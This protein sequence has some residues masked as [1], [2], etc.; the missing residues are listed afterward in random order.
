LRGGEKER[1]RHRGIHGACGIKKEAKQWGKG[2]REEEEE[3]RR[4]S[5][6]ERESRKKKGLLLLR[7]RPPPT[8]DVGEWR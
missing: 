2:G 3:E 6:R 4:E 1:E 5:E 7:L 8:T